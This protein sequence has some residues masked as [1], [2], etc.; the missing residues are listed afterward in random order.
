MS[1][2]ELARDLPRLLQQS[3]GGHFFIRPL[4]DYVVFLDL[5]SVS[6]EV[7]NDVYRLQPRAVVQTS[8]V[9]PVRNF[10]AWY[11]ID[12]RTGGARQASM[13][14]RKLQ[15]ALG[16]DP[17]STG[18]R[19][20]GRMPGSR[21][22]KLLLQPAQE[23]EVKHEAPGALLDDQVYLSV[24]AKFQV[25]VRFDSNDAIAATHQESRPKPTDVS[26][27]G[28]DWASAMHFFEVNPDASAEEAL[29]GIQWLAKRDN[30]RYYRES[31][32]M[33]ARAQVQSRLR[34]RGPNPGAAAPPRE[35]TTPAQSA[36]TITL[37][38][39]TR[40]RVENAVGR[41]SGEGAKDG[42]DF[43]NKMAN[44][45]LDVAE[46]LEKKAANMPEITPGDAEGGKTQRAAENRRFK[47]HEC[48][49]RQPQGCFSESQWKGGDH[50]GRK[51][52]TCC[53]N[54]A[55]GVFLAKS[56]AGCGGVKLRGSFSGTQWERQESKCAACAP[57]P[58]SQGRS[59]DRMERGGK[60]PPR[61][62]ATD[63]CRAGPSGSRAASRSRSSTHEEEE[64]TGAT[65]G[66]K[67]PRETTGLPRNAAAP[68][69]TSEP[70]EAD[71]PGD[72][73]CLFHAL[74]LELR[75]LDGR[76]DPRTTEELA[77]ESAALRLEVNK[78]NRDWI[79]GLS[80]EE[81]AEK[82]CC[83]EG[84]L[85]DEPQHT[86]TTWGAYFEFMDKPTSFGTGFS[87][88]GFLRLMQGK[89]VGVNVW[90]RMD[91]GYRLQ[92]QCRNCD[93][94]TQGNVAHLLYDKGRNHYMALRRPP[95]DWTLQTKTDR[96]IG[97]SAPRGA[98]AGQQEAR[99]AA[100][101]KQPDV[102][103]S[104][105]QGRGD[106][107]ETEHQEAPKR[108]WAGRRKIAL[109][110]C[111]LC[112][113]AKGRPHF[114]PR[115]WAWRGAAPTCNQCRDATPAQP[116]ATRACACCGVEK[117]EASYSTT[118]WGAPAR[119]DARCLTCPPREAR[120]PQE[121]RKTCALCGSAATKGCYSRKQW[122]LKPQTAP[123]MCKKCV[124]GRGAGAS[125]ETDR[126]SG[127][128]NTGRATQGGTEDT[129]PVS[130]TTL[131]PENAQPMRSEGSDGRTKKPS[132]AEGGSKT[133]ETAGEGQP[134]ENCGNAVRPLGDPGRVQAPNANELEPGRKRPR[135]PKAT[136][137]LCEVCHVQK[138]RAHF[139]GT[140]W[141]RAMT[142]TRR[143][144]DCVATSGG[145][146]IATREC[147][148][149]KYVVARESFSRTQWAEPTKKG[150]LCEKCA[151]AKPPQRAATETSEPESIRFG[152]REEASRFI[153]QTARDDELPSA[154]RTTIQAMGE[155]I[156]R[157][158]RNW[159]IGE[160]P[161]YT[162]AQKWEII[163]Q[164]HAED[165]AHAGGHTGV[166]RSLKS[167]G[168]SWTHCGLDARFVIMRC[169]ECA[170]KTTRGCAEA[171]ARHLPKPLRSGECVGVDLKTIAPRQEPGGKWVM[172]LAV[173][174]TSG[175]VFTWD[176]DFGKATLQEVQTRLVG[177]FMSNN[178][179]PAI[180]WSDNGGQFKTVLE[181]LFEE[182]LFCKCVF[183]PPGH[184][185][186]NGYVEVLNR[187]IAGMHGGDRRRLALATR[188][189]NAKWKDRI[190]AAPETAWRVLRP[191][192]SRWTHIAA[193]D[194]IRKMDGAEKKTILDAERELTDYMQRVA[195]WE[196][197]G[198]LQAAIASFDEQQGPIAQAIGDANDRADI[199]NRLKWKRSAKRQKKFGLVSG[200]RVL[201]KNAQV[202]ASTTGPFAPG[203]YE[204]TETYGAL[205]RIRNVET[206]KVQTVHNENCKL[207][208]HIITVSGGE[209]E[210]ANQDEPNAAVLQ[211][212]HN[213]AVTKAK[214][215]SDNKK[216]KKPPSTKAAA[217]N[218]KGAPAK[219]SRLSNEQ[220]I[221]KWFQPPPGFTKFDQLPN[222][223]KE[224]TEVEAGVLRHTRQEYEFRPNV[225]TAYE[226]LTLVGDETTCPLKVDDGPKSRHRQWLSE[227]RRRVALGE[228][229]SLRLFL[230][231][232]KGKGR[233]QQNKVILRLKPKTTPALQ[234]YCK[235]LQKKKK[236]RPMHLPPTAG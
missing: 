29:S 235:I 129:E 103:T 9:G 145:S 26:N 5:D 179:P 14:T 181:Q 49:R 66:K 141:E 196:K 32:V 193:Q 11:A 30:A 155:I 227:V 70:Q 27:S 98:V 87:I 218:A 85:L 68:Q 182:L 222:R 92:L 225:T 64:A 25:K 192:T 118:Q 161:E 163:R 233:R 191:K 221:K 202:T 51:C 107:S 204:V 217:K 201:L 19:Q 195:D 215:R 131:E 210:E 166:A 211:G 82:Q 40:S 125:S 76:P 6:L 151:S 123:R 13:Y 97:S 52:K 41:I 63:T 219:T 137:K 146:A 232:V 172:L 36:P 223:P 117:P 142:L 48:Q 156:R 71:V 69:G 136:R 140:Q 132:G 212:G 110:N 10:Q 183:I 236:L 206:G 77:Q 106:G 91:N 112:G 45:L 165:L 154:S 177:D 176:I 199:A 84:E 105:E 216:A 22:N 134:D 65:G 99:G 209:E 46:R 56:C 62:A 38:P 133:Q 1:V 224:F 174:F 23:V 81:R 189:Y 113:V 170:R 57:A 100:C 53:S 111:K 83:V 150:S 187:I 59:D 44:Y 104:A 95:T 164:I 93:R 3:D 128:E 86:F 88:G 124:A 169:V 101:P 67:L 4:L 108:T 207:C 173:D 42:A 21:N 50:V 120:K 168:R 139:S 31:T 33:K 109:R 18:L 214:R 122:E 73:G 126:N 28:K 205:L 198:D 229:P 94:S 58:K 159:A 89:G 60:Q 180:L 35:S 231:P 80:E 194:T 160:D 78:A 178:D 228:V 197:N 115:Q 37:T 47:C 34:D 143:C 116:A 114:T 43:M 213:N 102:E 149:C 20:Q 135:D 74:T 153:V 186:S 24:T 184:P 127:A 55:S 39:K 147:I 72:G 152:S 190:K 188:A 119:G 8:I 226:V 90:A 2:A 230:K 79:D 130:T 220:I 167:M 234:T 171:T 61:S 148:G 17:N 157:D 96:A 7:M 16:S 75:R 121:T 162:A 208:P 138:E 175:K 158:T 12:P 185:A 144:K 15:E 203:M 200:D 54:A